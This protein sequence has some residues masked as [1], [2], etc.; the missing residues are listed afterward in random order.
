LAVLYTWLHNNTRGSVLIAA[1]F[2]ASANITWAVI[3]TRTTEVGRW[4]NFVFLVAVAGTVTWWFGRQ[5]PAEA[6]AGR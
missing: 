2:H 6:T 5:R 4:V 1:L 3:P